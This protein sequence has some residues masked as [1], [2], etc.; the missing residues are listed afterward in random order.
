MHLREL[1]GA[2]F[3]VLGAQGANLVS[4]KGR[5]VSHGGDPFK[6]REKRGSGGPR[7]V[8]GAQEGRQ[9][10]LRDILDSYSKDI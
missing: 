9:T 2:G 8:A 3:G 7:G 5:A 4:G 6:L 10:Y 1:A